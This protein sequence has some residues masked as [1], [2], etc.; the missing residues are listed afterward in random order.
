[1]HKIKT[2]KMFR[3]FDVMLL[4]LLLAEEKECESLLSDHAMYVDEQISGV[5]QTNKHDTVFLCCKGGSLANSLTCSE[6]AQSP[7]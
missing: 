7:D 2:Y 5:N 4:C 3:V 1:M 6:T